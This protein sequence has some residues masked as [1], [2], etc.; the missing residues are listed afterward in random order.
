[1]KVAALYDIHGNLPALEAVL[2]EPDVQHA[3]RIVVGGDLVTGPFP[4][5]TFDLLLG[6]GFHSAV[7]R[8][9]C[10]RELEEEPHEGLWGLRTSWVREQLSPEQIQRLLALPESVS[11]DIDLRGPVFFCHA[12]P[13]SDDEILTRATPPAILRESAAEIHEET[14]V[15]GHTHVQ[16]DVDV[17]RTRFV[18]AGSVGMPYEGLEGAY[19]A[20]LGEEVELRRTPYDLELAAF[21]IRTTGFPEPDE[22]VATL[23]QP[24]SA[25]EATAYF[26]QVAGERGERH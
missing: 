6:L 12:S 9:N 2:A 24:P 14:I 16:F 26:E 17:G 25:E 15:L 19:W 3:H 10:E 23:K 22:F 8:G 1:M 20:L 7:I 13:R 4:R 21:R 11:L 18:N 5:E